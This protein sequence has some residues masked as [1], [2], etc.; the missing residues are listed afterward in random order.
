VVIPHH[1]NRKYLIQSFLK[2]LQL[3]LLCMISCGWCA[4][5]ITA[6]EIDDNIDFELN[7]P[8]V[9]KRSASIKNNQPAGQNYLLNRDTRD[10]DGGIEQM[11]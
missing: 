8:A 1:L 5:G 2:Y 9:I 11:N 7:L 4:M 10:V 6:A 3:N